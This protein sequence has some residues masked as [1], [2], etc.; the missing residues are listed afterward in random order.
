[1]GWDDD[2]PAELEHRWKEWKTDLQKLEAL[3]VPRCLHPFENVSRQEIHVFSDASESAYT[4]AVYVVSQQGDTRA[5]KLAMSRARVTPK[6]RKVNIQRLELMGA[7]LGARLVKK[8]CKMMDIPMAEVFFWS[9]SV[10]VL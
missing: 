1:M 7:L 9:D 8:V 2:L 6:S 4:A 3:T 10:N 5:S